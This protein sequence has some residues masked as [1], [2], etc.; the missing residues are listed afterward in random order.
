VTAARGHGIHGWRLTWRYL[1]PMAANPL[2][3]LAGLSVAS[4]LSASLLIEIVMSWPGLGPLVVDAV[5]ARDVPVVLAA[6]MLAALCLVAGNLLAD[7][8][9]HAVDPRIRG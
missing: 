5:L 1:L 6:S 8:A 9:L 2:V 4:L 3:S 7:V